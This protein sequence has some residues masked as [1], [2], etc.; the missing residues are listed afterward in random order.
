MVPESPAI[1]VE[2]EHE[3]GGSALDFPSPTALGR[4]RRAGASAESGAG[5]PEAPPLTEEGDG[6]GDELPGSEPVES[7]AH[8]LGKL[9]KALH[10]IGGQVEWR[11]QRIDPADLPGVE[12]GWGP[13]LPMITNDPSADDIEQAI[14]DKYGGGV[15]ELVVRNRDR[16]K[17]QHLRE[18][19]RLQGPWK[20]TTWEGQQIFAQRYGANPMAAGASPLSIPPGSPDTP[21]AISLA[22]KA[23]D[24]ASMERQKLDELRHA[25]KGQGLDLLT[26]ILLARE[27]APQRPAYDIPALITAAIPLFQMMMDARR[28]AA[29]DA[30]RR[31]EELITKLNS[32][33]TEQT[34]QQYIEATKALMGI[35]QE[36]AKLDL[37]IKADYQKHL[38]QQAIKAGLPTPSNPILALFSDFLKDVGP[39][40][41][42]GGMNLLAM[43]LAQ[44]QPQRPA[45]PAPAQEATAPAPAAPQAPAATPIAGAPPEPLKPGESIWDRNRVPAPPVAAEPV[46]TPAIDGQVEADRLMQQRALEAG[47]VNALLNAIAERAAIGTNPEALWTTPV[48]VAPGESRSAEQLLE[49]GPESFWNG[50]HDVREGKSMLSFVSLCAGILDALV[51]QNA[52]AFDAAL[53]QQSALLPFVLACIKAGPAAPPDGP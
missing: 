45:L 13:W 16:Q 11:V 19:V 52:Q 35:V 47:C 23:L 42:R 40:L 29:A 37:G 44:N 36:G 1:D 41:A 10:A 33:S 24:I 31:H 30:A 27:Q 5:L 15:Y 17:G 18:R 4:G 25:D 9:G 21:G 51:Q 28:E 50:W 48:M 8:D 20:P 12:M 46:T 3:A 6:A 39:D 34:P 53:T 7:A 32:R 26:K 22:G 2:P 38:M 14:R 49:G 43:K